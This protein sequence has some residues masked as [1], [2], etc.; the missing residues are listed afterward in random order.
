M[1]ERQR[2]YAASGHFPSFPTYH[3]THGNSSTID[4]RHPPAVIRGVHPRG[5]FA[6]EEWKAT[7]ARQSEKAPGSRPCDDPI[8]VGTR[9]LQASH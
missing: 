3:G 7:S 1:M 9:L 2:L 4:F 5:H 8:R 6:G